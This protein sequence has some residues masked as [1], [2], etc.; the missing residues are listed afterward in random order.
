[1]A[2]PFDLAH[3]PLSSASSSSS[4][5]I[6]ETQKTTLWMGELEPW[7]D[8]QYLRQLWFNLNETVMVKVIRDKVTGA[9]AGYA[10]VDFGSTMNAQRALNTFNGTIIPNTHKQFKLNWASGGG[11]ID[12]REDRQPEYSIFVGDLSPEC[13]ELGLL[14]VF[15]AHYRSCKSAKIMTDPRTGLTRG[16]GFVRFS[17]QNDQQRALMEMQGYII[18]SRPIRVSVA[19]PKNRSH[20][21]ISSPPT[22]SPRQQPAS[23]L[24]DPSNTTVFVGGLSAP[25]REDEL[26]Q[27]FSP[28]GDI[29]QVKIPPGK[30][31][32]F[33]QYVHRQSA[34]LAI[35]QMN[36]YQIGNSRIRLSWGRSQSDCA[37]KLLQQQ[38][39]LAL[40]AQHSVL[41]PPTMPMG[42]TRPPLYPPQTQ[43]LRNVAPY[44][45]LRYASPPTMPQSPNQPQSLS[46][47]L[48]MSLLSNPPTTTLRTPFAQLDQYATNDP[49]DLVAEEDVLSTARLFLDKKANNA[50]AAAWRLNQVYAQ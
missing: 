16:Y 29:M 20:S 31:C 45:G 6:P 30:G 35:Q 27:Y 8:E 49:L 1:M 38:Q 10:F 12:R 4:L 13:T 11:L 15:Q 5:V 2:F 47:N 33:V 7:M 32:G 14:G 37:N 40:N 44:A 28:F 9:S 25:I 46:A 22:R 43:P 34:E 41:T 21:S 19:T 24:P 48:D 3:Q 18:G 26:R 23:V 17:D 39:Q 42:L 36:G 50:A